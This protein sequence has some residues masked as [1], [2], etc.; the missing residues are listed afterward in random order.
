MPCVREEQPYVQILP[1]DGKVSARFSKFQE[2]ITAGFHDLS[3]F[4]CNAIELY[5]KLTEFHDKIFDGEKY[6]HKHNNEMEF[7]DV[8]NE[9]DIPAQVVEIAN[10]K[11]FDFNT[12]EQFE[13]LSR[14]FQE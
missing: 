13:Q 4:Y 8:F 12:V 9:T 2:P 3:I 1:H 11:S 7:L 6:V 10:Y 5:D 14:D